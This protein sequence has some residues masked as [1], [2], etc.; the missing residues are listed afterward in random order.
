MS[1]KRRVKAGAYRVLRGI[2]WRA[3]EGWVNVEAS[4][5]PRTD[6]PPEHVAGFIECGAIEPVEEEEA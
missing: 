5:K 4:D 6:I 2:S 1:G 3:G